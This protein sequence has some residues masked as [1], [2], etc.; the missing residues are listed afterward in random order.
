MLRIISVSPLPVLIAASLLTATALAGEFVAPAD[1]P[2]TGIGFRG[3]GTGVFPHADPP[4]EWDERT[5]KN[6]LWKVELPNWGYA[7]PVPVGNRVIMLTE[8]GYKSLWPQLTCYDTETGE[9]VW[10]NEIVA[11]QAKEEDIAAMK[12]HDEMLKA[13]YRIMRP[14]DEAKEGRVRRDDPRWG[15]INKQLAKYDLKCN[16][17]KK[18]YGLLRYVRETSD[19]WKNL[20]KRLGKKGIHVKTTWA[21]F[22]RARIGHA[23][24]TPVSDGEDVYLQTRH[25]TVA[26]YNI[27]NGRKKW[28]RFIMLEGKPHAEILSSPRLYKDLLLVAF[29]YTGGEEGVY[30]FDRRTGQTRWQVSASAKGPLKNYRSRTGGSLVVMTVGQ[31]PVA[32]SSAGAVIRLPDGHV[33]EQG[34][35]RSCGTYAIDERGDRMFGCGSSDRGSQSWGVKLSLDGGKLEVDPLWDVPRTYGGMSAVYVDGAIFAPGWR[36]SAQ[37]GWPVDIETRADEKRLE[38][39]HEARRKDD[40]RKM[41][42]QYKEFV[43]RHKDAPDNRHTMLSAAGRVYGLKELDARHA[44]R[45][46][47]P[48]GRD[49]GIA[50]VYSTSGK[51]LAANVLLA[52]EW[53]PRR[54]AKWTQQGFPRGFSYACQMNIAGERIYICSQDYLYCIGKEAE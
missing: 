1:V 17:F 54:K 6:I 3:D 32:L 5:G 49:L 36:L 43:K 40:R 38:K 26:C 29:I 50:E 34:I 13:A 28:E 8:P 9:V 46:D 35:P 31:T 4:T 47:A 48:G 21:E 44:K 7:S 39:I 25:G 24:P 2:E 27:G 53:T 15:P 11:P 18:G 33:Y 52:A 42:W 12:A 14:I 10:Q 19:K 23:F 41:G 37:D 51:K 30:A 20:R 16:Q 45:F 22:G